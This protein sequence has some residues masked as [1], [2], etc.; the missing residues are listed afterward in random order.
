[1]DQGLL[2]FSQSVCRSVKGRWMRYPVYVR[3]LR[4][5]A[6]LR[7]LRNAWGATLC[8][9]LL[10]FAVGTKLAAYHPHDRDMKALASTKILTSKGVPAA[11]TP[12]TVTP[13]QAAVAVAVLL[14]LSPAEAPKPVHHVPLEG[15]QVPWP[16]RTSPL[17]V[18]PPPAL[19]NRI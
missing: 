10:F 9:L 11:V 17:A 19:L 13:V 2:R 1:M 4:Q 16:Y 5:F 15:P 14:A 6:S 7:K 3:L 18:R 8:V 12:A